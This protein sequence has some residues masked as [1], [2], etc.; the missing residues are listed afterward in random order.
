MGIKLADVFVALSADNKQLTKD[1]GDA[2][3]Q[4]QSWASRL[5]GSLKAAIPTAMI[6]GAIAGIGKGLWDAAQAAGEEEKGIVRLQAAVEASGGT[7]D[8][9]S[10][11]IETYIAKQ[12]QRTALDDGEARDA[13]TRLITA[14]GD[15][16]KSLGLMGLAQD[17]AIGKDIDLKTAAE[18]VGKVSEGNVSILTRYGITLQDGATATEALAVLQERFGGQAEAYGA[19]FEG[20]Q[21]RM[22]IAMGNLK[23]TIGGFLLPILTEL[24][25]SL[26]GLA[27]QAIPWVEDKVNALRPVFDEVFGFIKEV[28][29]TVVGVVRDIFETDIG[30]VSAFWD[31]TGAGIRNSFDEIWCKIQAIVQDVVETL[32]PYVTVWLEEARETFTRV[33]ADI[34]E[35]VKTAMEI[36]QQV[37]TYAIG[38]VKGILTEL[39]E[40]WDEHGQQIL[41]IVTTA[42]NSIRTVIETVIG[43]VK[44]I[45]QTALALIRGDWEGAW[46]YMKTT[47]ET[48]WDGI[49][50][51]IENALL[52][53]KTGLSIAWDEIGTR[54]GAA[55]ESIKTA[56][57]T[58]V[59]DI[60]TLVETKFNE[61]KAWIGGL[62]G[63]FWQLGVD[64]IS[65]LWNGMMGKFNEAK[66]WIENQMNALVN[67]LKNALGIHSASTVFYDIAVNMW[68][69]MIDATEAAAPAVIASVVEVG[70]GIVTAADFYVGEAARRLRGISRGP[71]GG[72]GDFG[73]GGEAARRLRGIS[74]GPGGGAGDFG[75]GGE[76]PAFRITHRSL[77]KKGNLPEDWNAW[78]NYG[79]PIPG[80]IT[81]STDRRAFPDIGPGGEAPASGT[82]VSGG[83]SRGGGGGGG[84]GSSAG[85]DELINL[86]TLLIR[87]F[88]EFLDA[89]G[90]ATDVDDIA[91]ELEMKRRLRYAS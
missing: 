29:T 13:L 6:V 24:F 11:K 85:L 27:E 41:S 8:T 18:I 33:W 76:A 75:P 72:A 62:P 57:S 15:Y 88:G 65:G 83:G 30:A 53:I 28:V 91:R 87:S 70:Q 69:G 73:P 7:W 78:V 19:T 22:G 89:Q 9:A 52:I 32:K 60:K 12:S 43:V 3:Q 47:L 37:V 81:R 45:L 48:L 90:W 55:W 25:T 1:L 86:L 23:E 80:E 34:Q 74:R 40:F 10:G 50:R 39:K 36:V 20:A 38:I 51:I 68:Q 84:G 26:A 59:G 21:Q 56:I 46:G 14:T 31:D 2:E 49:K 44:G 79:E 64:L 42:F 61:I 35:I 17:L 5:G 54:V 58:K 4:G 16:E 67:G 66:S 77:Q 82:G 71:G 63:A